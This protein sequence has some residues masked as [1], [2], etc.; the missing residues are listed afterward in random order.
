MRGADKASFIR[1]VVNEFKVDI[2][3]FR[4]KQKSGSRN[5]KFADTA[6]AE[7]AA[8]RN[9]FRIAPILRAQ[10]PT[11][12]ECE[13]LREILDGAE[14]ETRAFRIACREEFRELLLAELLARL[15]AEGIFAKLPEGFPPF[16]DVLPECAFAGLVAD[17]AVLVFDLDIVAIDRDAGENVGSVTRQVLKPGRSE[18]MRVSSTQ[19]M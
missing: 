11:D 16:F 8:D 9:A 6:G 18:M 3:V 12:D 17:E 19:R 4:P 13:L 1:I 5:R 7:S 10:E 14:H 15:V 2:D